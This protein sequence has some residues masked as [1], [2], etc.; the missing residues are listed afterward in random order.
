MKTILILLSLVCF[1]GINDING[2]K[3]PNK[4]IPNE[5]WGTFTQNN[6]TKLGAGDDQI[7]CQTAPLIKGPSIIINWSSIEPNDNDF[8]F[9]EIIG[10]H[11]REF[12]QCGW[13]C[14]VMVWVS[15]ATRDGKEQR[16]PSWLIDKG[17]PLVDIKGDDDQYPDYF[18]SM[19]KEHYWRMLDSLATISA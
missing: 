17:V 16:T 13:K 18:N 6:E 1:M 4:A 7:N 10:D 12:Q 8:R 19:Y 2:Q 14:Y 9:D 3:S 15:L 5:N 11:L